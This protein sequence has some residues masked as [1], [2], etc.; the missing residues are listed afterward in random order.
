MWLGSKFATPVTLMV[1]NKGVLPVN[2][3]PKKTDEFWQI[4]AEPVR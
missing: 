3:L 4:L 1:Y 2:F